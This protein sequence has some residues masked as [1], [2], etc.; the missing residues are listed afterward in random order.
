[1]N[2]KKKIRVP[3]IVLLVLSM[4]LVL[5][6]VSSRKAYAAE[7]SIKNGEFKISDLIKSV[8]D[9]GLGLV[10]GDTLKI[11][12]YTTLIVDMD[13][14]IDRIIPSSYISD[15]TIQGTHTLTVS[16]GINVGTSGTFT[17]NSGTLLVTGPY[18]TGNPSDG[19]FA[20]TATI[21]GGV[22]DIV[23]DDPSN[24]FQC[25]F[26]SDWFTLNDGQVTVDIS[27]TGSAYTCGIYA[28]NPTGSVLIKGGTLDIDVENSFGY[29]YGIYNQG[30]GY[31]VD[32]SGGTTSVKAKRTN[33][34]SNYAEARGISGEYNDGEGL[35]FYMSD[36]SLTV[37]VVNM[38]QDAYG[39][40]GSYF[41]I[42]GGTLDIFAGT[43]K[44]GCKGCGIMTNEDAIFLMSGGTVK[45]KGSTYSTASGTGTGIEYYNTDASRRI[46]ISGG[47]LTAIG[48][49]AGILV[50]NNSENE[51]MRNQIYGNA[52]VTV[53][54]GHMD[55]A[56]CGVRDGGWRIFGEAEL[57]ST[58]AQF[59]GLSTE[60]SLEII[61][62]PTVKLTGQSI[63]GIN[64]CA[65]YAEK[66]I[67]I[68]DTLE[69]LT[70]D[71]PGEVTTIEAGSYI[72]CLAYNR[73]A[74]EAI[75]QPKDV[76]KAHVLFFDEVT[77]KKITDGS[78]MVYKND[79][80]WQAAG[81]EAI[82]FL[83]GK[84]EDFTLTAGETAGS[85]YTFNGW[86]KGAYPG[87]SPNKNSTITQNI[88]SET[89]YYAEFSPP[90]TEITSMTLTSDKTPLPGM[91]RVDRPTVTVAE[92]GIR[93]TGTSWLD[94]DGHHLAEDYVFTA[95]DQVM[96]MIDY[97]VDKAYK[98]SGDIE[99]HTTLNG[100]AVTIHDAAD[101]AVYQ[102]YT[103]TD[104][105]NGWEK[106]DGSWY[107]YKD[108]VKQTGWLL[109][110][111]T[112]YYLDS[113]GK[114]LTG[115]VKV[116][117]AW[118]YMNSSGA[119]QTGWLKDGS[120]WYYLNP[121]GAMATGWVKVGET[122]YY[123]ASSGA[124]QTGWLKVGST[125]YYFKSSGAMAASEW[126]PGYYWI[127]ASGAWT[128]QPVGSWKKDSVGWWFGDTSGWYAKNET[129]KIN[130]VNYT[131]DSNGYWVE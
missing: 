90:K 103:I 51:L 94:M 118:Y 105:K 44:E 41:N 126:V 70:E 119:M 121:S 125:W 131:F 58:S 84:G 82:T 47:T 114:M 59:N 19:I 120:T 63:S 66:G 39:I 45:T 87:T 85:G 129:L 78:V 83:V 89:W 12:P 67:F 81:S 30:S 100:Q 48:D 49:G 13:F 128:Y 10:P 33:S 17:M 101:T 6:P 61:D 92:E 4:I 110:G 98:L 109:D 76:V 3:I 104:K 115:W 62:T 117:S 36:G 72:K 80:P 20:P 9:G 22:I 16:H 122:W 124:M 107:Y 55:P 111:G 130:D 37:D 106:E 43:E 95:G 21:N 40:I 32:I 73:Y 102:Y 52:K 116:G 28:Y 96:L 64:R 8:E 57:T 35:D 112:W 97:V 38:G 68:G 11:G 54:S 60:G 27:G 14:A 2:A 25:G 74:K 99:S 91:T 23:F 50:Y 65:V 123:M 79:G 53:G 7:I 1:M 113:T 18:P 75:I 34:D 26:Y 29:P 127:G 77:G 88:T 108:D 56:I 31:V 93:I 15:L 42:S 71:G 46:D 86:Y 69:I 24:P 5:L